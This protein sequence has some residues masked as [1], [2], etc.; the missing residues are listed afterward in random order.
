MAFPT[1]Y[2]SLQRTGTHYNLK[3]TYLAITPDQQFFLELS[4]EEYLHGRGD[5]LKHCPYNFLI[6]EVPQQPTCVVG[7]FLDEA[8]VIKKIRY[9]CLTAHQHIMCHLGA[10]Q[11]IKKPKFKKLKLSTVLY[12]D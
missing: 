7:L 9:Y 4:T 10:K 11:D 5:E 1:P 6:K 8:S 2:T 12:T 3:D